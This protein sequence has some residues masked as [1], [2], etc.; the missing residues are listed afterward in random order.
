MSRSAIP[1]MAAHGVKAIHIGYNGVGGLP[2]VNVNDT[3]YRGGT[4]F[5]GPDDSGC[6]A[7]A[8][9]RWVEPTTNTEL[10]TMIEACYGDEVA[11]PESVALA[12]AHGKPAPR[13]SMLST[14]AAPGVA[15]FAM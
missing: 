4:S 11:V 5:C 14:A 15:Q 10:L 2:I 1:T 6:P 8:I 9:F 7:E 12:R 13:T 3:D